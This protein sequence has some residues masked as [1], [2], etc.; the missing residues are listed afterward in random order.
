MWHPLN[1]NDNNLDLTVISWFHLD[2]ATYASWDGRL[3]L[4]GSAHSANCWCRCTPC[5]SFQVLSS[6][7]H[8]KPWLNNRKDMYTLKGRKDNTVH[9]PG[10]KRHIQ[11]FK[12]K[13]FNLLFHGRQIAV[14][15]NHQSFFNRC[16]L[17]RRHKVHF[18]IVLWLQE[19]SI[20]QLH[21]NVTVSKL[22]DTDLY[23]HLP[24]RHLHLIQNKIFSKE[25]AIHNRWQHGERNA[26]AYL[27]GFFPELDLE[28]GVM[29]DTLIA[30]GVD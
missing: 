10:Y 5:H 15:L 28:V 9:A 2:T 8:T 26:L 20:Q 7:S 11:F 18:I 3:L 13:W 24:S 21:C 29:G 16:N 14:S 6:L 19:S 17:L 22:M 25:V 27:K 4:S 23:L 12:D 30:T 1:I